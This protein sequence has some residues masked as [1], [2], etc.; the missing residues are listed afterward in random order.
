MVVNVKT[1][2]EKDHG[3]IDGFTIDGGDLNN[4]FYVASPKDDE[5]VISATANI[6][7]PLSRDYEEEPDMGRRNRNRTRSESHS[8]RASI[9]SLDLDRGIG[10]F[11]SLL[12]ARKLKLQNIRQL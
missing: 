9:N 5:V 2:P 7:Q 4:S 11:D 3:A 1:R 8:Q 6:T 10:I 12:G